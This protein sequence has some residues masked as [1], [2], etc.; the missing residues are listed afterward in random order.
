VD[1]QGEG[2]KRLACGFQ[3]IGIDIAELV[4]LS[5]HGRPVV[6][7]RPAAQHIPVAGLASRGR[8]QRLDA[9]PTVAWRNGVP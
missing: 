1:A 8:H 2:R 3:R 4:R 6:V 9:Q 5:V 7:G